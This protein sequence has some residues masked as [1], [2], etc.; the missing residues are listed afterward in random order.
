MR[1]L[2]DDQ[3][4]LFVA[5]PFAGGVG[6]SLYAAVVDPDDDPGP[7]SIEYRRGRTLDGCDSL[8]AHTRGQFD[9]GAASVP[10]TTRIAAVESPTTAFALPIPEAWHDR[11]VWLQVR[12]FADDR[13]NETI[14][15]PQRLRID[16]SGEIVEEVRGLAVLLATEKRDAGGLLVRFQFTAAASAVEPEQFLLRQTG[17]P[18]SVDDGTVPYLTGQRLYEIEVHD[19]QDGTAYTFALLGLIGTTETPLLDGIAFTA[20][21]AG[22]PAVLDLRAVEV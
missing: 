19:L 18:G 22:P 8:L 15:R 9:L 6:A 21:A 2:A 10:K 17:G 14:Y 20:D 3:S 11:A 12:T 13:E 7:T 16:D 1:I 4:L 5:R